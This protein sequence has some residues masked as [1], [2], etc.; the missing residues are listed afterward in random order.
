MNERDSTE[1]DSL[2]HRVDDLYDR[3]SKVYRNVNNKIEYAKSRL[4]SL[5]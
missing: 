2:K 4:M 5:S 3:I 1:L